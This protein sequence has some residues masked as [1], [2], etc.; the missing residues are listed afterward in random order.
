MSATTH[1]LELY[2]VP[3]AATPHSW[4]EIPH[5][6]ILGEWLAENYENFRPDHPNLIIN[7][8]LDAPVLSDVRIDYR[9]EGNAIQSILKP[10]FKLLGLAP[11]KPKTQAQQARGDDIEIAAFQGN[12]V[13]Y[14]QTVREAFGMSKIYPDYL[15]PRRTYF[16]NKR[17]HWAEMLLCV[18]VG[19]YEIAGSSITFGDTPVIALG[20]GAYAQVYQP[21]ESL[22][23]ELAAQWWHSVREVGQTSTGNAGLPLET[24]YAAT[25]AAPEGTYLV[26]GYTITPT[27]GQLFPDDW[28]SGMYLDIRYLHTYAASGSTLTGD[29][30]GLQIGRASCRERV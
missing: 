4:R 9:P 19:E 11:A 5:G 16:E 10:V 6:V 2:P 1:R 14:G 27:G 28:Q 7:Q 25:P 8:P 13:K 12:Q 29:F 3:F 26:S 17:N 30:S 23:S 15:V 24:I 18:G 22:A 21:G 20:G